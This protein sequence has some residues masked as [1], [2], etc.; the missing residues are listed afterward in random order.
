MRFD[1][2]ELKELQ[3]CPRRW[4]FS[5][6]NAFH[7][8]PKVP[9]ENLTFG[10]LFH[11]CLA[12]LYLGGDLDKVL[13]QAMRELSYSQTKQKIMD[14]MLRGYCDNVLPG[15]LERFQVLD[16]ERSVKFYLPNHIVTQY[17]PN[18][19]IIGVDEEKSVHV[20]GSIDAIVLDRKT[21]EVFGLEHKSAQKL[22]SK[23]NIV[24][25]EQPRT[26][27]IQ[28]QLI[29]Q[30]MTFGKFKDDQGYEGPYEV[31]G[32]YINEVQKLQKKFAHQRTL[33]KYSDAEIDRFMLYLEQTADRLQALSKG[34]VVPCP[35]P[36]YMGCQMCDYS[37][38]CEHIGFNLEDKEAIMDEFQ[39]E[40]E[41]R[42]VDHLDEKSERKIEG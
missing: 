11:E 25:D 33:C 36:S 34:Q 10:S 1:V 7:M 31:G 19:L 28:L 3:L 40:F 42:T 26:Y 13:A 22:R 4:R 12:T 17:D 2:S 38:I 14:N 5:S 29:A 21:H 15:D 16:I 9:N 20:C 35:T 24:M 23:I 30:Q 8:R 37:D 41:V 18:G 32:I 27:Y 6:R 39:E